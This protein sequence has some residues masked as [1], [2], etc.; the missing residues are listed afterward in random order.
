[1]NATNEAAKKR[2]L[3]VDDNASDTRLLKRHLE[4]TNDFV[5]REENDPKAALS[6]AED[7]QP[8][9]ILLDL[10]M[11]EIDGGELASLFKAHPQLKSVPIVFLTARLTKKEVENCAGRVGG[12]PFLAK[13][14]VLSEVTACVRLQLAKRN[15]S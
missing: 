13:P 3:V 8:H 4:E 10:L 2:I 9:L 14:I 6:A 12:Y 5:V 1:M 15:F 11:P 7:F